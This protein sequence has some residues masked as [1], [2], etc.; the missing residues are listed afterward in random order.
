M[1]EELP[2]QEHEW[3][4]RGAVLLYQEHAHG[5]ADVDRCHNQGIAGSQLCKR[6]MRMRAEVAGGSHD[7]D[8]AR[9]RRA[10]RVVSSWSS[11]LGVVGQPSLTSIRP[12]P[13]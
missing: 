10:G 2:V 5:S 6:L 1:A 4:H 8:H 12:I 9:R 3:A 7:D 11:L 13:G